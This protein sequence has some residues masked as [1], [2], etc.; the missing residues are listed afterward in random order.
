M[1]VA[2]IGEI[3]ATNYGATKVDVTTTIQKEDENLDDK[4]D[5][6]MDVNMGAT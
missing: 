1:W 4:Q 6:K 5:A 2:T 3:Y